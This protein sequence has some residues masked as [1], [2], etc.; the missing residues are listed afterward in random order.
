MNAKITSSDENGFSIQIDFKYSTSM[1]DTEKQ[2]LNSINEAGNLATGK[3]LSTF[4]ANGSPIKI[5]N[6]VFTSKGLFNKSYQTPYG[7]VSVERHIYQSHSG[8]KTHCP[9]EDKARI[10]ITS[11]PRFAMIVSS[12]YSSLGVRPLIND[13]STNHGRDMNVQIIQNIADAVGTFAI[14]KESSWEY[15]LPKLEKPVVGISIGLDGTCMLMKD[16]G[17]REAMTGTV[18]V[19]DKKGERMHTAY[20]AAAP[21]YGKEKFMA[22]FEREVLR[23]KEKYSNVHVLGLADGARCNWNFLM[24]HSDYQL[25]DFYHATQ[26]I[27]KFSKIAFQDAKEREK[28]MEE[29][30]HNLK[31]NS[32]GA[33]NFLKEVQQ[34]KEKNLKLKKVEREEIAAVETYFKNN[35][36]LMKYSKI[37]E[38]NLP[39]GSGSTEAACKVIVKE[40]MCKS[41]MRWK[42]EGANV[43]LT[44]RCLKQ[45][46]GRWDQFWNK[47]DR[48]G[49]ER[50]A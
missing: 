49:F 42:D 26:Y 38:L 3:V 11:T 24:K 9:L 31:H 10:I 46:D 43:V 22:N 34:F 13:L 17:W 19:Y 32:N 45:T 41:G 8:G 28:W 16:D 14:A 21:E 36:K 30:C 47:V 4:D 7:E 1:L 20:I 6:Q 27:G 39:I 37:G 25:I 29:T 33:K 50:A 2:I 48:Y 18:S 15:E 44:L 23:I 35:L 5:G 12:K 40:R